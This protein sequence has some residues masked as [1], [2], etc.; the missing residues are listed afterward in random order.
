MEKR[1]SLPSKYSTIDEEKEDGEEP[2]E[3]PTK[4]YVWVIRVIL[5]GGI[6]GVLVYCGFNPDKMKNAV[7]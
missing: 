1:A 7:F 2:A 3:Q 6:I 4:W 5:L